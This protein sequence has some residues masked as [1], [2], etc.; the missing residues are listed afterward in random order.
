[1]LCCSVY[2]VAV[3]V[4][5]LH[6]SPNRS[7]QDPKSVHVSW[8][9]YFSGLDK[10]LPST[11]AF[12][13]PPGLSSQAA[14][15][16]HPATI[17]PGLGEEAAE[18]SD[19]L[20]VQLLVR[21]YQVR[22]HHTAT[23]DPLGIM[24][25]D[26]SDVRPAEL[27]L[28]HYGWTEK[29]LDKEVRFFPSWRARR[30]RTGRFSPEEQKKGE[31]DEIDPSPTLCSFFR[32]S[33]SVLESSLASSVTRPRSSPSDRSSTTSTGSTVRPLPPICLYYR[34]WMCS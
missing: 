7:L 19:H 17:A 1:M 24:E 31:D 10:G 2:L 23:L 30:R 15:G 25:A 6:C 3:V 18:L 33:P 27:E 9:T 16:G 29:D 13:P 20:K 11:Q 8:A 26:L 34:R 28:D 5:S 14:I 32:R 22:G 12:S 21:A 4:R